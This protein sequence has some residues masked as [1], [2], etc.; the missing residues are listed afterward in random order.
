MKFLQLYLDAFRKFFEF[1]GKENRTAF[2]SFVI[3]NALVYLV[4][5]AL[6]PAAAGIYG[7]VALIPSIML[8]IRRGRDAGSAWLALTL[9]IPILALVVL[10]LLPSKR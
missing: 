2:W 4:L 5:G 1:K 8:C 7:L 6:I 10:G 9:L 3:V